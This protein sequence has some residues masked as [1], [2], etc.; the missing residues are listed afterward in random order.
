MRIL[1]D[2]RTLVKPEKKK[3][4]MLEKIGMLRKER[5][6]ENEGRKSKGKE[7]EGKEKQ[8]ATLNRVTAGKYARCMK[9]SWCKT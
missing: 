7:N 6:E 2:G 3:V 9:S 8:G 4:V 1:K 5:A